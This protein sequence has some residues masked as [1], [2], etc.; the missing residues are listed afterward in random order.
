MPKDNQS[1]SVHPAQESAHLRLDQQQ[2]APAA[3][4]YASSPMLVDVLL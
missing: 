1:E 4:A 3:Q 2:F